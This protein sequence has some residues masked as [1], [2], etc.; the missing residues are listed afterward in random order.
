MLGM[1]YWSSCPLE[2]VYSVAG[3][4]IDHFQC[5][6]LLPGRVDIRLNVDIP[7]DTELVEP[8]H[9]GCIWCQTRGT[10]TEVV[11]AEKIGRPSELVGVAQQW[12]DE[13]DNLAFSPPEP[14][15]SVENDSGTLDVKYQDG[16]VHIDSAVNT[17][18]GTSEVI[19]CAA[20]YLKLR[21]HP[22]LEDDQEKCA[23]RIA[24]ILNPGRSGGQDLDPSI[25]LLLGSSS[26]LRDLI[27]LRPLHVR[28]KLDTPQHPKG[29]NAK[30]V[31]LTNSSVEVNISL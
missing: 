9:E 20:M 4:R 18:P 16:G 5:F 26:N 24:D 13:L 27:F 14:E 1:P 23:A 10:A 12:Y 15:I 3:P 31:I 7:I 21:R 30:S 2:R 22:D 25:Q 29:E 19:I 11:V 8:L 6:S 17:S 28:V